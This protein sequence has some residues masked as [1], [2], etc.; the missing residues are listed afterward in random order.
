MITL[1]PELQLRIIDYLSL[2]DTFNV[3][4]T[5]R[6]FRNH[7]GIL[8]DLA[9]KLIYP[10]IIAAGNATFLLDAA[11]NVYVS[12]ENLWG[13]LGL[14]DTQNRYEFTKIPHLGNVQK[15]IS[16][17]KHS[18]F[19]K[20]DGSVLTCGNNSCGQLGLGDTSDR[21]SPELVPINS[22]KDIAV[23][24]G[25]TKF[26]LENGTV[27]TCGSH[28]A[29]ELGLDDQEQDT[30]TPTPIENL[31]GVTQIF[32]GYGHTVLVKKDNSIWSFGENDLGQLGLGHKINCFKPTLVDVHD[33]Q[34][35]AVRSNKTVMLTT[36]GRVL[37]CGSNYLSQL[38][39]QETDVSS[40]TP[41]PGL[42]KVMNIVPGEYHTFFIENNHIRSCGDFSY[43]KRGNNVSQFLA[44]LDFPK[45]IASCYQISAGENHTI[46]LTD[47]NQVW[48][49]GCLSEG[50]LGLGSRKV[51]VEEP[52]FLFQLPGPTS[53]LVNKF[54]KV[55]EAVSHLEED[56][57][58]EKTFSY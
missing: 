32:A 41:V 35:I 40:L 44:T 56:N 4:S 10:Q 12:G 25:G 7:E 17:G 42:E 19:I 27:L 18:F 14:G 15:I 50:Q 24:D 51:S 46:I 11:G 29:K 49:L 45:G 1:P 6:F 20:K 53:A 21:F 47:D 55:S 9:K 58:L 33:V 5:C 52:T 26:L 57:Q 43:G 48:G 38:G 31:D 3:L 23:N 37:A 54:K 34:Q 2:K 22:V 30:T 13:Q 8:W 36:N 39:L 16:N 28:S